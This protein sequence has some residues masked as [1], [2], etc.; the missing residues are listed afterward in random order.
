SNASALLGQLFAA[1]DTRRQDGFMLFYMG[2]NLGGFAAP[3]GAGTLGER[4]GWAYG[5][6]A[7]G[8][9]MMIG[10]AA[11]L[12]FSR[13]RFPRF[14]KPAPK[15]AGAIEASVWRDPGVQLILIMA[16]FASI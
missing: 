5:F 7:A 3:Y 10:L 12:W 15:P 11:F 14:V 8:I 2:I 1:G 13:G 4:A 16:F 6:F 9:G